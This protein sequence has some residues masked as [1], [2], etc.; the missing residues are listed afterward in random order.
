M[1]VTGNELLLA[2]QGSQDDLNCQCLVE[3]QSK[4]R[5]LP[6]HAF[7]NLISDTNGTIYSIQ[8]G[9]DWS[10]IKIFLLANDSS[11]SLW[12]CAAV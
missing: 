2:V 4:G 9:G 6:K 3:I 10:C 12:Y 7:E 5:K 11:C 8:V 1:D